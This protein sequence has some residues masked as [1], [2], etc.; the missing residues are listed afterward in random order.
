LVKIVITI[1]PIGT[2]WAAGGG[3]EGTA[4]AFFGKR[5][6][7]GPAEE[8]VAYVPHILMVIM[9]LCGE[10]VNFFLAIQAELV[11]INRAIQ[12]TIPL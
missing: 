3:L 11:L 8:V 12:T 2:L 10:G 7:R 1:I 9:E 6:L 4:S 5:R